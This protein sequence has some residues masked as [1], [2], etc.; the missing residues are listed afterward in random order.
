M[1]FLQAT[2]RTRSLRAPTVHALHHAHCVGWSF[3]TVIG[4]G[5]TRPPHSQK[6]AP[7]NLSRLL[8]ASMDRVVLRGAFTSLYTRVTQDDVVNSQHDALDLLTRL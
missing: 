3:R 5:V 7:Q 1:G 8:Y 2:T 6:C 4:S